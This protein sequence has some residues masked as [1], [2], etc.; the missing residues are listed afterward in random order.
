[1]RQGR[2]PCDLGHGP[3]VSSSERW[4]LDVVT[5]EQ[6]R[7]MLESRELVLRQRF[8]AMMQEMTETRDLLARLNVGSGGL[9]GQKD[10]SAQEP[11]GETGMSR[12][13]GD[14]EPD[15]SP[16]RQRALRLLRV[17]GA[18]TNCRKSTQEVLGLAEAFDDIRKQL[19]NNRID[20][21]ELKEPAARRHRRAAPHALPKPM[22]P[23]LERRLEG[24][25]AVLDDA[26]RSPAA[27]SRAQQQADEILLAMR[28]VRDRMIEVEDFNE[29]VGLLREIIK[30]QEQLHRRN[31]SS[32]TSKKSANCSRSKTW[33]AAGRFCATCGTG[34]A[35]RLRSRRHGCG[36]SPRRM[37][38]CRVRPPSLRPAEAVQS[39]PR[40]QA[41][42]R[43]TTR[44]RKYKHLEDVLLR[45]AELSAANDPRRA[46]LLK[47]AVAQSK[48]QLIAVRLDRLV[49]LLGK[50]QLSR[51]WR[52]KP[53][54][55][56]T[57]GPCWNC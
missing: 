50:D 13:P 45:M 56:R 6:L 36:P 40:R 32:G 11:A 26:A 38:R 22:F 27:A 23:E 21:E 30:T 20:T 25:Q 57:C 29:A 33:R 12:E 2:R 49:E 37:R 17:E 34:R 52:T 53:K 15:D 7:T 18:L 14:D 8:D 9:A 3:N 47:K 46:A 16:A 35:W 43:R 24:L 31:Q 10:R 55:T 54:S 41:G 51:A 19:I 5:P 39:R 4:L 44:R 28:K 48:D 42:H 1:M